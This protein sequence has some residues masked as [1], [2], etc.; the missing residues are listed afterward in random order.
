MMTEICRSLKP[1]GALRVIV[2]D[3]EWVMRSYFDRPTEL[4]G[5]LVGTDTVPTDRITPVEVVNDYF[6][7]RYEH[8]FLYD[9]PAMEKLLKSAGFAQVQ[10]VSFGE[11]DVFQ[12]LALDD[13][14]Y[15]R[16]SLYVEAR[17]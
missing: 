14:K 1:K 4:L 15:Q 6:R 11:S 2:P 13:S 5:H 8:H 16:E 12:D 9:F 7:Q 10:R 17:K 3:A